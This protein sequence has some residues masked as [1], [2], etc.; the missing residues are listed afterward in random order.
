VIA[1]MF[2]GQTDRGSTGFPSKFGKTKSASAQ[3]TIPPAHRLTSAVITPSTPVNAIHRS[4]SSLYKMFPFAKTGTLTACLTA[5]ICCQSARPYRDSQRRTINN[6]LAATT[7]LRTRATDGHLP[8]HLPRPPMTSQ[9]ARPRTFH[10]LGI[11]DRLVDVPEYPKL[12]S[13]RDREVFVENVDCVTSSKASG[14]IERRHEE[15]RNE[16]EGGKGRV[17]THLINRTPII[18]Q[19][20]PIIPPLGDPL[21]TAAKDAIT[22]KEARI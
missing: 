5:L 1:V 8:L 2:Q 7:I 9:Y 11:L 20:T 3:L 21:R 12:G 19:K 22:T 13:H 14:L 10:H 6:R 4:T 15:T 17:L 18:L 16:S